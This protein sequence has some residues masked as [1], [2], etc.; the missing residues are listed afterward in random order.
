[1]LHFVGEGNWCDEKSLGKVLE[2]TMPT[3]ERRGPI[4]LG[5]SMEPGSPRTGSIRSG[6]AR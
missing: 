1:L 2:M 5:S 4:E 3:I 6:V